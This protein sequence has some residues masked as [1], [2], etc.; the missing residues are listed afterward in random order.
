MDFIKFINEISDK[1]SS[2]IEII[3]H[4]ETQKITK[5]KLQKELKQRNYEL[6]ILLNMSRQLSFT[7][8]YEETL[9]IVSN[10]LHFGVEYDFFS[11]LIVS[12]YMKKNIY[13]SLS[14]TRRKFDKIHN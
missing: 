10:L 14:C 7:S 12:D 4:E 5:I 3:I 2:I 13:L 11:I 8:T 6:E 9:K 1:L